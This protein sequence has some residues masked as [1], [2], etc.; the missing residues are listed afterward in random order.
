MG[1]R[2]DTFCL[3]NNFYNNNYKNN[4]DDNESIRLAFLMFTAFFM[5]KFSNNFFSK[6]INLIKPLECTYKYLFNY[7][8]N[9]DDNIDYLDENENENENENNNNTEELINIDVS[10]DIDLDANDNSNN[11][12][13]DIEII[14]NTTNE[15]IDIVETDRDSNPD[16]NNETND[17]SQYIEIFKEHDFKMFLLNFLKN[18]EKELNN[19]NKLDK[20]KKL[21]DN[22]EKDISDYVYI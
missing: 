15:N 1:T 10:H 5:Y 22:L 12:S 11:N 2:Y 9:Y 14:E 3:D 13:N 17:F 7:S 19:S 20:Y 4:N 21:I 16:I 18:K 6:N 8:I